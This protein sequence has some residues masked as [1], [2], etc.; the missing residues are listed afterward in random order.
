MRSGRS[1]PGA[2]I[3]LQ[4]RYIVHRL[5]RASALPTGT[6]NNDEFFVGVIAGASRR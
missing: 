6:S 3:A 1:L 4:Q 2:L 5:V